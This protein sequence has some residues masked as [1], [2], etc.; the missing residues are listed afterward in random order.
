MVCEVRQ[1]HSCL[2]EPPGAAE[3]SMMEP[4]IGSLVLR[5]QIIVCL[6]PPL[7][8]RGCLVCLPCVFYTLTIYLTDQVIYLSKF[9]NLISHKLYRDNQ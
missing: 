6:K 3:C 1:A 8:T 2:L 5:F 9:K 7:V 4:C